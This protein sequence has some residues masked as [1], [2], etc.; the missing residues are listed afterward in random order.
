MPGGHLP[1]K[2]L[3]TIRAIA[4]E[5]GDGT[6]HLTTRQ[7]MELPDIPFEKIPE[8]NRALRALIEPLETAIGVRFDR[9]EK[10]YP[11]AGTRNVAACIGNR[12]CPFA[13]LDTTALAMRIE[14]CV[15]PN[16]HHLKIAVTGC[17]NDCIKAHLQDFGVVGQT[18]IEFE[19]ERCL[20]CEA[21]V[22]YCRRHANDSLHVANHRPVRDACRCLGCGG[23]VLKCPT[24]A[25]SRSAV[26]YF[27][28]LVLGRTGKRNPRLA[29]V[30]LD[31]A[32][33]D[34]VV[35]VIQNTY[36]FID[37]HIDRTL[38]KE[39]LGYIV[40][41]VGYPAFRAAVLDDVALPEKTQ[42]AGQLRFGVDSTAGLFPS[43]AEAQQHKAGKGQQ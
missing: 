43:P 12:V 33:E 29:A 38:P 15:L 5:Y 13:N 24:G 23:C 17:A 31:W 26:K 30:F 20:G 37:R 10:G 14:R 22:K 3:D 9:R 40:D 36:A 25:R 35:R 6:L 19:A 39:H 32:P 42:V 11:A 27:R 18:D 7:G 41:R 4:E 1:A 8:V 34:A 28:L 16:E 2:H 21:C